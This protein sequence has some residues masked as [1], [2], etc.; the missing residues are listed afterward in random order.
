MIEGA[1]VITLGGGEITLGG[2][3]ITEGVEATAEVAP[4][5]EVVV[6]P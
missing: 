3:A 2:G 1:G 6:A 4:L 5:D